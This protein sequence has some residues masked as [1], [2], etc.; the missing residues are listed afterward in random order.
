M[1]TYT[2]QSGAKL[3]LS[4][5]IVQKIET[6][7]INDARRWS[8]TQDKAAFIADFLGLFSINQLLNNPDLED[9]VEQRFAALLGEDGTQYKDGQTVRLPL[10]WYMEFETS[11]DS[12]TGVPNGCVFS[13]KGPNQDS[14]SLNWARHEGTTSGDYVH[15]IPDQVHAF[16]MREE[17]DE[18]A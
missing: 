18:Y 2:T 12:E 4:A 1:K 7:T 15:D 5:A 6:A 13:P 8:E 14:A 9:Q 10:G 17:F 16:I 11:W 3:P